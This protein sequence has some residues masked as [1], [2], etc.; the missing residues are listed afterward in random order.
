MSVACYSQFF[1]QKISMY[2]PYF[3]IEIL[4]SRQLTTFLTSRQLTTFLSFEQLGPG[5]NVMLFFFFFFF[6]MVTCMI[7]Q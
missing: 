6:A 3:E 4:T 2:L 1:Q 5:G 7:A